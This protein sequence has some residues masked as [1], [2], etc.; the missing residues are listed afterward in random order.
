MNHDYPPFDDWPKEADSCKPSVLSDLL[1]CPFCGSEAFAWQIREG[2]KVSCKSDC[3]TMPPRHDMWFTS[4][5]QAVAH[6]NKRAV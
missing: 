3:V 1:C 5:E 4:I 2:W 6:W